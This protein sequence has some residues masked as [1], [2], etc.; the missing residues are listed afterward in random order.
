MVATVIFEHGWTPNE[1]DGL[2]CDG[3]DHFGLKWHYD[4]I[5]EKN[6]KIRRS[7]KKND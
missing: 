3:I 6:E 7:M 4:L 5:M 1:I 2:F